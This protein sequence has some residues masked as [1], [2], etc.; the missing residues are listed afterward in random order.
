MQGRRRL[1]G[2]EVGLTALSSRPCWGNDRWGQEG[3]EEGGVRGA[4]ERAELCHGGVGGE[5]VAPGVY[6]MKELG[7]EGLGEG[8]V[9]YDVALC[10][11]VMTAP[12]AA[13]R[14]RGHGELAAWARDDV[15]CSLTE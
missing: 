15:I 1:G 4:Q 8:A 14:G 10:V 12:G 5:Q 2:R 7:P 9:Q 13:I 3:P 11:Q 6:A